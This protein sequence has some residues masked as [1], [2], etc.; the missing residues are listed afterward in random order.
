[1][2]N[3]PQ[4]TRLVRPADDGGYGIDAV[5]NDD[6]HHAARVVLSGHSEAYVSGYRGSPQEVI[7]AA[8]HGYLYQGQWYEWQKKNRGTPGIE[9]PPAAFVNYIQ[10]HD[11]I[12]NSIHGDRAHVLASAGCYRA[13]T[14]LLLLSPQT[15]MLFQGQE[16]A[17]SRPFCFFS[18][19]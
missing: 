16:F 10:N 12:A 1:A 19:L 17:S 18:D 8:K 9:L 14:A 6:F 7:S 11:Q 2:E 15:P 3:E 4:D 5:W 13:M